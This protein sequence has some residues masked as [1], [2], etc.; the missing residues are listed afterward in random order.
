MRK[1]IFCPESEI[2]IR[3]TEDGKETRTIEGY[4]IVFDKRSKCFG[5][6]HK[7][8][9]VYE[10]ISPE[11]VTRELLDKSDILMTINH[12]CNQLLARSKN[13]SGTLIYE[14]DKR[15]V[16]FSFDAPLNPDGERALESV[17]R[18]DIDGC[19]FA[20]TTE[21]RNSGFVTME[22]KDDEV[23]YTVRKFTGIYDFTLTPIPAYGDTECGYK[24]TAEE[25]NRFDDDLTARQ[26]RA[27]EI[28][29]LR[30]LAGKL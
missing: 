10:V 27:Q 3:K 23:I 16:K 18:G 22:V 15:G 24:R 19:S 5:R 8:R 9:A 12:D 11:A 20:F 1:R 13:G 6:D 2:R 17:K 25:L 21:Y 28:K 14:I 4:A 26:E 29:R 30:K 7:G